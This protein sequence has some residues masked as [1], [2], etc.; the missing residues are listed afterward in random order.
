MRA[1]ADGEWKHQYGWLTMKVGEFLASVKGMELCE[2]SQIA[3]KA[4]LRTK[5]QAMPAGSITKTPGQTK[6]IFNLDDFEDGDVSDWATGIDTHCYKGA[7]SPG[8]WSSSALPSIP[9][10]QRFTMRSLT[11]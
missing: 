9:L 1:D 6:A 8:A 3:R 5:P 4:S 2:D 11:K 7:F 10:E